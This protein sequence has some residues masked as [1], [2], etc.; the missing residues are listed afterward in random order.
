M[1]EIIHFN[2]KNPTSACFY[3]C[4]MKDRNKISNSS[5]LLMKNERS[6]IQGV[7]SRV[8]TSTSIYESVIEKESL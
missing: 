3:E 2:K 1:N 4:A 7:S 6:S 5:E 8:K